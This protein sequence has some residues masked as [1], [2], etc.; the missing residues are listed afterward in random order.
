MQACRKRMGSSFSIRFP[1]HVACKGMATGP[2]LSNCTQRIGTQLYEDD[3]CSAQVAYI[4]SR[5]LEI[6]TNPPSVRKD[7]REYAWA[8]TIGKLA[9]PS[10]TF[11]RKI[12]SP[13]KQSVWSRRELHETIGLQDKLYCI[14]TQ[15]PKIKFS[16]YLFWNK[17]LILM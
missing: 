17:L 4:L 13:Q 6:R 12:R 3:G 14:W 15:C 8:W 5:A 7:H 1:F 9:F 11:I 16:K 10:N 2:F